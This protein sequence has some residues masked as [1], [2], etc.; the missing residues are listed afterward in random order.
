[1]FKLCRVLMVGIK[2]LG[3]CP[4][5]WCKILTKDIPLLGTKSDRNTRCILKRY[6]N[7]D[8]KTAISNARQAIYVKNCGVTSVAVERELDAESLTPASVRFILMQI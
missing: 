5:P 3:G 6:D 1:M 8:Q 2:H 7:L 4:C